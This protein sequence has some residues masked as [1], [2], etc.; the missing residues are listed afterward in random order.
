MKEKFCKL[1][2]LFSCSIKV[3]GV[4][5]G[6]YILQGYFAVCYYKSNTAYS[7]YRRLVSL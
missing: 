5:G 1:E 7:L 2:V 6:T 3:D 4:I